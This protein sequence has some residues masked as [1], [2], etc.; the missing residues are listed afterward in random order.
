MLQIL[1]NSICNLKQTLRLSITLIILKLNLNI[2]NRL[3][4]KNNQKIA[5]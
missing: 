1:R 4:L 2:K 3:I 5:H